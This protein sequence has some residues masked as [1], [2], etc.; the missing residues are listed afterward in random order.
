MIRVVFL[1]HFHNHRT[2][3]MFLSDK[4]GMKLTVNE[5][6]LEDH[7]DAQSTEYKKFTG[8]FCDEVNYQP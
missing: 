3:V 4:V 5:E 7:N 2:R 1:F 8:I 6:F